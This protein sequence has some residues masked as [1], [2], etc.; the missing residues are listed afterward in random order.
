MR[1][2]TC[3]GGD[4]E[5]LKQGSSGVAHGLKAKVIVVAPDRLIRLRLAVIFTATRALLVA[6]RG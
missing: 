6:A 1:V 4:G 3:L 5:R 2:K